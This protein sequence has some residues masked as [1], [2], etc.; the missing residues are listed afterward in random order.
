MNTEINLAKGWTSHMGVLTKVLLASAGDV[1]EFGSGPC[2][3]PLLHWLCKDMNRLLISYENNPKFYNLARQ[4]QSRLH[5]I[6]FVTNYNEVDAK[7]H[8]GLVF[9]DHDPDR[10]TRGDTTLLFKNSADYIVMHDTEAEDN[11]G[12]KKVWPHFKYIY[13][14]KECQPWVSVV[15]NFK[16]LSWLH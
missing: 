3:T 8:R 12:Y 16:N 4:Y 6:R 14:W 15:S 13:T 7:T 10:V 2:S 9:V 11:Y 1:L 5:R